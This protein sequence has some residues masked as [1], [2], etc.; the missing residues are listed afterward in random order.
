MV[1]HKD[2]TQIDLDLS[3]LAERNGTQR[4]AAIMDR[5]GIYVFS[6]EIETLIQQYQVKERQKESYYKEMAFEK[7]TDLESKELA[8]FQEQ[9]FWTIAPPARTVQQKK[10]ADNA[11]GNG[12]LAVVVFALVL[13]IGIRYGKKKKRKLADMENPYGEL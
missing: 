12:I 7:I 10:V 9:V 11:Y 6:P 8:Y 2:D 1:I 13:G 5:Y 3:V 4:E